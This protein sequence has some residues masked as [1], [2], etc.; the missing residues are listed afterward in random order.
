MSAYGASGTDE[1]F[2]FTAAKVYETDPDAADRLDQ[3]RAGST[4]ATERG[5]I[6]RN[7]RTGRL[8]DAV[9]QPTAYVC[10]A[11]PLAD[12]RSIPAWT[13]HPLHDL[14]HTG[15][16]AHDQCANS[17]ADHRGNRRMERRHSGEDGSQGTV[18]SR[19]EEMRSAMESIGRHRPKFPRGTHKS[20]QSRK[21]Q[22]RDEF[23]K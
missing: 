10:D 11:L 3:G 18:T 21:G 13:G 5:A 7:A 16:F 2:G 19:L 20:P 12:C 6:A 14:R 8:A 1:V 22:K 4:P 9:S 23:S 17:A 15:R